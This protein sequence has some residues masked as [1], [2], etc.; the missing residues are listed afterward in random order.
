MA[1]ALDAQPPSN[2]EDPRLA[3]ELIDRLRKRIGR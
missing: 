2:F 1:A 3:Q